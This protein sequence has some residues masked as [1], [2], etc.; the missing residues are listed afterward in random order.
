MLSKLMD[1]IAN[2]KI[3]DDIETIVKDGGVKKRL[4]KESEAIK[5]FTKEMGDNMGKFE[6]MP[7]VRLAKE[8]MLDVKGGMVTKVEALK[9]KVGEMKKDKVEK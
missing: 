6:E 1:M 2:S 7:I 5:K 3:M 9:E 8:K 4:K